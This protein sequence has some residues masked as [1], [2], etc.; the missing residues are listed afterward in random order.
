MNLVNSKYARVLTVVLLLQACAFYALASRS[1][2]TPPIPA[3][4]TFPNTIGDWRV[5][6]DLPFEKEVMDILKA[7]DIT[8]RE[9]ANSNVRGRSGE[10][11]PLLLTIEYFKTQRTGQSPHSPKNCLP[12]SGWEP[13]STDRPA[14]RVPGRQDPIVINRYIS[15]HGLDKSVVLYW[16]QSH[17]RV[18]ASE[19]YS[20]F[21]LVADAIRYNRSDVSMVK[22]VVPVEGNFTDAASKTATDFVVLI[23]P[24]LT[25]QLPL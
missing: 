5:V 11:I 3:L 13:V 18:V 22:I 12:G 17:G 14:I 19:Y 16:Y 6:R 8:N 10:L 2:H 15:Q 20:K 25:K 7:D 23:Y 1:E 9:Y 21:W 24:S 4:S